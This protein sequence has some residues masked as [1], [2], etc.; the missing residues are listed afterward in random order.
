MVVV[1]GGV[2]L[3]SS[4]QA[5]LQSEVQLTNSKAHQSFDESASIERS[6]TEGAQVSES[7]E[8]IEHQSFGQQD[9]LLDRGEAEELQTWRNIHGYQNFYRTFGSLSERELLAL[10]DAGEIGALHV[11]ADQTTHRQ[12]EKAIGYYEKAAVHGSTLALVLTGEL[13]LFHA[14]E[15]G[16]VPG[17]STPDDGMRKALAYNFA[18][19]LLDD[20]DSTPSQATRLVD[21]LSREHL[22]TIMA[23]VCLEAKSIVER[24]VNT[25]TANGY[26]PYGQVS[27]P[28]IDPVA[29]ELSVDTY[30]K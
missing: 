24:I 10:A 6:N 16:L 27:A 26:V 12:P 8:I 28:H 18:A 14:T 30:C 20:N 4:W 22:E 2:T 21:G 15:N 9:V 13:L 17:V 3:Y 29:E 5:L 19:Q 23:E 11:L 7:V 25:R 1:A